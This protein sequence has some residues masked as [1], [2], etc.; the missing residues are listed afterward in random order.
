MK[1]HL[2]GEVSQPNQ[3]ALLKDWNAMREQFSKKGLMDASGL[4]YV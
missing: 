2:I 4:Y 1:Q 3:T